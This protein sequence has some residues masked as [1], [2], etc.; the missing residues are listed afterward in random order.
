MDFFSNNLYQEDIA[1]IASCDI[2]WKALDNHRILIT[3]ATGMI[4]SFFIDTLMYRNKRYD[5]NISIYAV[6]RNAIHAKNR[7]GMY[8]KN[9]LFKFIV[10]D[11]IE[12][13]NL[14]ENVDY[15]IHGASNAYPASF[16]ADPVG[17]MK[18]NILGLSNLFDY[19]IEKNIKRVLYISS[20]E[21]Y[22]EGT[23][24][25]FTESYSGYLDYLNPRSCY[26]VS[27]RATETLCIAYSVQHNIDAVI[28]RPCHI[29]GPTITKADNRAFAQ[30]TR[31]VLAKRDV[32]LKSKGDQYRSYCYVAD[33][34]SAL[35][36]ILLYG[37]TRNSYNISGKDSNVS[38]AEL[39]N[40]I[41]LT[42]GRKVVFNISTAEEQKGY[43]VISRAVLDPGKLESLG[44]QAKYTLPE[45]IKRTILIL[46]E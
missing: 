24:N 13:I 32:I 3:G 44:W 27:K 31:D 2:N 6:I 28:V 37:E 36:V 43:S 17:I 18:A 5:S 21:V 42:G 29:Y 22:G 30:F 38:I 26:P 9:P 1:S 12:K 8:W 45:G 11:V 16:V 33:C 4:G 7:F 15:I 40:Y 19:G 34:V 41:A 25:D 20:G 35:L 14:T 46:S 10:Q 39:A 23:G